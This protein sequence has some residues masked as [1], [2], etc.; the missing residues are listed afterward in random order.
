M[1]LPFPEGQEAVVGLGLTL[2]PNPPAEAA[3]GTVPAQSSSPCFGQAIRH[4]GP[5]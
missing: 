5:C 4:S 2:K 1:V 3:L